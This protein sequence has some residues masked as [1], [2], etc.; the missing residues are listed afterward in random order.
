MLAMI[1]VPAGAQ[2]VSFMGAGPVQLGMTVEAA[3]R[4]MGAKFAPISLPFFRGLLDNQ[5][6]GRFRHRRQ[7]GHV[8]FYWVQ[9]CH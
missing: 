8:V 4:A 7:Q 1:A 2:V 3:E 6:G 9:E 5:S